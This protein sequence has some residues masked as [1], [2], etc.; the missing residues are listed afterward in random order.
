MTTPSLSRCAGP[1]GPYCGTLSRRLD[2]EA[3]RVSAPAL[4]IRTISMG[5]GHDPKATGIEH[6]LPHVHDEP[7]VLLISFC[8]FCGASLRPSSGLSPA[9]ATQ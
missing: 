9:E 1:G 8:P 7:T 5:P 2:H 6:V 4:R 3:W